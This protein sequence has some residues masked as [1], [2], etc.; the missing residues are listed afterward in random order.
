MSAR[1]SGASDGAQTIAN[2]IARSPADYRNPDGRAPDGLASDADDTAALK[3]AL[4]EGPGVV[5]VPAGSYRFG[6]VTVPAG[7]TL[8]GSGRGTEVRL[9][10]GANSVFRQNGVSDWRLRDMLLDGGADASAWPTREDLGENGVELRGCTGFE[11]SGLAVHNFSGAGIQ[12]AHTAASPYC[13][14]ATAGH[15]FNIAAGKAGGTDARPAGIAADACSLWLGV[16]SRRLVV[17]L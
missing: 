2:P 1:G 3:A 15:M 14:W 5:F 6:D 4:A 9:A 11:L 13:R 10:R 17:R 7:V 16:R 8:A 12:I